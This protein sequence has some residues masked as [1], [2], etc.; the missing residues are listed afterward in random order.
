M[1]DEGAEHQRTPIELLHVTLNTYCWPG[2][3]CVTMCE[4][5]G[6]GER[7]VELEDSSNVRG[8][9]TVA[10][11]LHSVLRSRLISTP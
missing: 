6:W 2:E 10:T 9:A 8:S 11:V 5:G 7:G 1:E 3:S 4:R